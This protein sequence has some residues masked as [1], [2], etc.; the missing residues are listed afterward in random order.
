MFTFFLK[1]NI[2]NFG[3]DWNLLFPIEI[4]KPIME[5]MRIHAVRNDIP[6]AVFKEAAISTLSVAFHK[7]RSKMAFL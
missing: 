4:L 5:S 7:N 1:F 2:S 3:H 6:G